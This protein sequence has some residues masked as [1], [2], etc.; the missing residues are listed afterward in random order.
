MKPVVDKLCIEDWQRLE[1]GYELNFYG[2]AY[3]LVK[4]KDGPNYKV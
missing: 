2:E 3:H 4:D 1:H